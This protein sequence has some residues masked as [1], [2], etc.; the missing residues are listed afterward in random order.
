M[1][2]TVSLTEPAWQG[3][4]I[5]RWKRSSVDEPVQRLACASNQTPPQQLA[6]EH[7]VAYMYRSTDE[8]IGSPAHWCVIGS[9]PF[10]LRRT[11]CTAMV[12]ELFNRLKAEARVQQLAGWTHA[13]TPGR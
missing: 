6:T 13:D 1:L 5:D 10:L 9:A 7:V 4:F 8:Y 11:G 12:G 2:S 3:L